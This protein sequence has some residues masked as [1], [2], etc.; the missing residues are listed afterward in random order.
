MAD[1][2]RPT[3]P[4]LVLPLLALIAGPLVTIAGTDEGWF[5][6]MRNGGYAM[7]AIIGLFNL[8]V[9]GTALLTFFAARGSV[10]TPWVAL[11]ALVPA[12]LGP[13]GTSQG[14]TMVER[15]LAMVSA[16]DQPILAAAGIAEAFANRYLAH[17]LTATLTVLTA[18]GLWFT[19]PSKL[20]TCVLLVLVCAAAYHAHS[21]A[22]VSMDR[23]TL[24]AFAR[25]APEDRGTLAASALAS[26]PALSPWLLAYLLGGATI[27]T[28]IFV[29]PQGGWTWIAGGTLGLVACG[30]VFLDQHSDHR[31]E[32]ITAAAEPPWAPAAGSPVV[33]RGTIRGAPD[34][35]LTT[36]GLLHR[37]EVT[38]LADLEQAAKV[39]GGGAAA[40]GDRVLPEDPSGDGAAR[41]IWIDQRATAADLRRLAIA[42]AKARLHRLTF[43]GRAVSRELR[44]E[45]QPRLA[46]LAI[47]PVGGC[48]VDL[49]AAVDRDEV[50]DLRVVLPRDP[51][52]VDAR[53]D[54]GAQGG[55]IPLRPVAGGAPPAPRWQ[56]QRVVAVLGSDGTAQDVVTAICAL[57]ELG[58]RPLLIAA[59]EDGP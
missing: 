33:A 9:L 53:P 21:A 31:A 8:A 14:L 4:A 22:L 23:S 16:A 49:P 39:L 59:E 32:A 15:A 19:P 43:A 37:G 20:R 29:A 50:I 55:V 35:G 5:E 38:P 41:T 36:A 6:L 56:D 40:R 17:A 54:S 57:Q 42:A 24:A 47:P 18:A 30:N 10:P 1:S 7:Y 58:L 28:L 26:P 52:E 27:Y 25:F 48:A 13:V 11:V 45:R 34:L 46:P 44:L 51:L 3:W 12:L 2:G